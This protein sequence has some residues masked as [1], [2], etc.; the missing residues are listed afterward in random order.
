MGNPITSAILLVGGMGTRMQPLTLTT[1]KPMLKVAGIPFT[2]HQIIKAREAGITEIVL[3][4]SYLAEIFEPYFGNGERFG[5]KISYAVEKTALGTGGAIRNAASTLQGSGPVVIFN[6]DVLSSHDLGKQMKFH[7]DQN[8]DATL[9]LTQVPDARAFGVVEV[10]GENRILSF[11][12]KMETPPTNMIN[13]G[14][15][16]FNRSVIDSIPEG[17]VVSVERET[18]PDVLARGMQLFGYVD[19]GYWLDIG[20]PNALLRATRDLI[21]GVATSD[22][23]SL[24]L[25]GGRVFQMNSQVLHGLNVVIDQPSTLD[26]GCYI[27]DDV[28]IASDVT[29]SNCVIGRGAQ[30]GAKSLLINTFIA[31]G[32]RV[33]PATLA[34]NIFLGFSSAELPNN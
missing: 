6:G 3:A 24:A 7:S 27:D 1:P 12:E 16:I 15:Y 18:F 5:I 8:A 22:A 13:A 31:P 34:E 28:V 25:T 2:E 32:F 14:C 29:L 23:L 21:S 19:S 33:P 20:N 30:I 26:S 10:D 11:N 4:T 9:Y 17:E